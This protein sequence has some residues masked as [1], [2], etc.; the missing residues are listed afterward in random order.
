MLGALQKP[1][2]YL[3]WKLLCLEE[4]GGEEA[5]GS[6]GRVD[7]GLPGHRVQCEDCFAPL[8]CVRLP[9]HSSLSPALVAGVLPSPDHKATPASLRLCG[10][11]GTQTAL[12][13]AAPPAPS[14]P[15]RR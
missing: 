5:D 13:T 10:R 15:V 3:V 4:K 1:Q 9:G 8:S 2:P 14:Y 12:P 11:R 6:S 7:L